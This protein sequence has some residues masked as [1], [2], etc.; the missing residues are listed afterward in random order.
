MEIGV[1]RGH[2]NVV[3][4]VAFSPNGTQ[5]ASASWDQTVKLWDAAA[6]C[7]IA[8]LKGHSNRNWS[9]TFSPNGKQIAS[10]S[11]DKTVKLWD[12]EARREIATLRGH[13]GGVRCVAYSSDGL[14]IASGSAT[15]D[16]AIKLWDAATGEETAT[17]QGH[18]NAISSIAFS[19]DGTQ[20]ASGG[21][22]KTIKLWDVSTGQEIT[23]F[24]GHTGA[25]WSVAFSPDGTR[26]ISGSFDWTVKLWDVA[27]GQETATLK[28]HGSFVTSALFSPDGTRIV[29]GSVDQT[30]K[31]WDARPWT[32]ELRTT[33]WALSV[34]KSRCDNLQSKAEVMRAIAEDRT[35]NDAVRRRAEE[36][37]DAYW[38]RRI[39]SEASRLVLGLFSKALVKRQAAN[40]IV[41]D[42]TLGAAVRE[43][44]LEL[45]QQM[46]ENADALNE[47]SWNVVRQPDLPPDRYDAALEQAETACRE[48]PENGNYWNTLGVAQYRAGRYAEA[49]KTLI[50]S[51]ELNTKQLG[52]HHP[53]DIAFLSMSQ[54]RLRQNDESL[55]SL[56]TLRQLLEQ[57]RWKNNADAQGFLREAEAVILTSQHD[58][59]K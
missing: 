47:A 45:V 21:E 8:T 30:V 39:T 4:S 3:T 43:R 26:I 40:T 48:Q 19:P 41:K 7:E 16:G 35:I 23:T 17:L 9:V 53:A 24:R 57:E 50:R 58:F 31:L 56:A 28:G 6:R 1:L 10:A 20:L 33:Q 2:S 37:A 54:A 42:P 51:G 11:L 36:L 14:R 38:E 46:R 25:V 49:A 55:K 34:V 32:P 15:Q 22:D 27:T 59:S 13:S 44:A 18:T 12:V 5:I 29:S 52:G